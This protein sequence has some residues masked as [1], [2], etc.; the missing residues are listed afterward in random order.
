MEL[1][2]L[3]DR[4]EAVVDLD[5]HVLAGK[6]DC[7]VRIDP[8]RHRLDILAVF[9]DT[10][11][12]GS[13]WDLADVCHGSAAGKR[14]K[15]EGPQPCKSCGEDAST[16]PQCRGGPIAVGDHAASSSSDALKTSSGMGAVD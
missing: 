7:G 10:A 6:S 5:V 3:V 13:V 12:Y 11:P 1:A 4:H 15:G 16:V 14:G 8:T 2:V 9:Q